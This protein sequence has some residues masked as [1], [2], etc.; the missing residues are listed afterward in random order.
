MPHDSDGRTAPHDVSRRHLIKQVGLAGAAAALSAAVPAA[1]TAQ[2]PAEPA[3]SGA[4]PKAEP[5]AAPPAMPRL[6][7]LETLTAA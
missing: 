1:A 4:V 5:Q 6:E 2:T 7:A 3:T